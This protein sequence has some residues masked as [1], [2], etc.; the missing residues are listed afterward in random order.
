MRLVLLAVLAVLSSTLPRP[1]AA[2]PPGGPVA[3]A[4]AAATISIATTIQ[5]RRPPRQRVTC[6]TYRVCGAS[7]CK[8]LRRCW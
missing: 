1:A 2:L 8:T 5:A 4:E 3:L 6:R 7:G